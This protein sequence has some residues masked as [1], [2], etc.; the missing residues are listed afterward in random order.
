MTLVEDPPRRTV[1]DEPQLLFAEAKERRRRRWVV[2]GMVTGV[3]VLLL[4]LV[5]VGV[6]RSDSRGPSTEHSVP[7][8]P[9]GAHRTGTATGKLMLNAGVAASGYHSLP[10]TVRF[11]GPQGTGPTVRVADDGGFKV[12]LHAG[13]YRVIGSSPEYLV[14][15][16]GTMPCSGPSPVTVQ[17]G[18]TT[19]VIVTCEGM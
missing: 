16:P 19:S 13:T 18:K 3:V 17:A 2:G 12:R 7:A 1:P 15:Q 9:L 10:G 5:S 6:T 4:V 14:G 11:V 8:S